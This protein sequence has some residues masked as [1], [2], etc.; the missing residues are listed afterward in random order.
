M[1]K[2]LR[3]SWASSYNET[4]VT[5]AK[6]SPVLNNRLSL[7]YAPKPKNDGANSPHAFSIGVNVLNRLKDVEQQ[8]S[9]TEIT[10]TLNYSYTF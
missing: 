9:F 2:A 3:A 10:G 4:T 8:P 6:T 7:N 1:E 5:N